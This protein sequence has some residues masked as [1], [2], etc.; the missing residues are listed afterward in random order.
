MD[1]L[2]LFKFLIKKNG[3]IQDRGFCSFYVDTCSLS[4]KYKG[5][6]QGKSGALHLILE[7]LMEIWSSTSDLCLMSPTDQIY[8]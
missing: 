1:L 6:S 7:L 8:Q 3:S 5:S 2:P 4:S